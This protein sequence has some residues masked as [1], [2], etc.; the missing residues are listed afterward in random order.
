MVT[1][2]VQ[3][4][5]RVWVVYAWLYVS[6]EAWTSQAR[7]EEW[8]TTRYLTLNTII[9]IGR[10]SRSWINARFCQH[11]FRSPTPTVWNYLPS[12]L[13]H[14][15]ISREC[16]RRRQNLKS[17]RFECAYSLAFLIIY[18]HITTVNVARARGRKL[19]HKSINQS[20]NQ[21]AFLYRHSRKPIRG[22]NVVNTVPI[23]WLPDM[24]ACLQ[25]LL[26]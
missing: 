11:S 22:V 13:R 4:L 18:T 5:C 3:Q 24:L 9:E 12:Q 2:C 21:N 17:W 19:I 14:S 8:V 7:M 16:F 6:S 15:D 1:D 26:L 23:T 25:F 10:K 20:I